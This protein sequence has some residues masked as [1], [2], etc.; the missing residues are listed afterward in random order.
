M[1]LREERSTEYPDVPILKDLSYDY[2]FPIINSLVCPKAVPDAIVRRLDDAFAKAMKEPSFIA[3][4]KELRLPV[5]YRS[6]KDLEDFIPKNYAYYQKL[7]KDMG[8]IK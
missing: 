5:I 7:L 1:L 3:G 4:M 6:G 8:V 2:P